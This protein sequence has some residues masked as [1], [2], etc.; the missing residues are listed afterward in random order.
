MSIVDS[1]IKQ[2]LQH[3]E[4]VDVDFKLPEDETMVLVATDPKFRFIEFFYDE[5]VVKQ[6]ARKYRF[7]I[8][9]YLR[10]TR[11]HG[12]FYGTLI[13]KNLLFVGNLF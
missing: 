9:D 3:K 5:E 13:L 4:T 8:H 11:T 2:S 1:K 7:D 10:Y 6:S 12:G